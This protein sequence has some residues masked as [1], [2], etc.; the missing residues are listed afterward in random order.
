MYKRFFLLVVFLTV[1]LTQFAAADYTLTNGSRTET[2]WATYSVWQPAGRDASGNWWPEGWRTQ[3]W[4]EIEPNGTRTLWVPAVITWVYIRVEWDAGEVKPA[5]YTTRDAFLFWIHPSEAFTSVETNEGALLRSTHAQG[6][7]RQA[8]I[9][10]VSER[11]FTYDCGY[12]TASKPSC[13][14]NPR[15]SNPFCGLDS[16]RSREWLGR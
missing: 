6:I 10:S 4:Y 15:C 3:G 9:V 13:P 7:L 16:D 11:R 12:P 14:A 5:N 1:T 8:F 2:V